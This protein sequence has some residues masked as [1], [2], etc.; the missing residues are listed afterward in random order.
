MAVVLSCAVVATPLELL[1]PRDLEV[2]E[3]VGECGQLA[4]RVGVDTKEGGPV[5]RTQSQRSVFQD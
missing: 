1:I 5:D 2:F 3:G 4:G